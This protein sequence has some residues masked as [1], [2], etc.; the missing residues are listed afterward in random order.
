MKQSYD[1][2]IVGAGPAGVCAAI[3]CRNEGL[4][5]LL[6]DKKQYEK[7][8]DKVC[9]EAISKR[10]I[11]TVS[12]EL[13]IEKPSEKEINAHVRELVLRTSLPVDHI[14]LPAI[15]YMVN[16]HRYG[17]RLLNN[18]IEKGVVLLADTKVIKP[19]IKEGKVAG[20]IARTQKKEEKEY[21]AQVVIDCSGL[22]AVIRTNL[23][24]DFEPMLNNKLRKTDYAPCYR[25]IIELDREHDL[26]GKIVLQYEEGIPNPG[27]IWFF[28]DG[29]KRINCGTGFIKVGKD[30]DKSVKS[31]YFNAMEN[32]YPKGTYNTIDGR[33]DSVPIRPPLWNAVAPGL[34]IAGDA[35]FHA[36]P[37]TAEGHGPAM[38]AG[39]HA[40]EIASDAIKKNKTDIEGL[41][42]YNKRVIKSFGAEHARSRILTLALQ[43]LGPKRLEFLLTRKVIKQADLTSEGVLKKQ[44]IYSYLDRAMR[45]IPRF[46][47]LLL[48][49]KA[50]SASKKTA[51]LCDRYPETPNDFVS[52]RQEMEK[53]YEG[54]EK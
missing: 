6:I 15:G 50:I 44:T 20:I 52:W 40:G 41:W 36:D 21:N 46:G 39:L 1:V 35:A 54:I 19:I 45:S 48:I 7:I 37:L 25:E 3:S 31:V 47:L 16:R 10:T 23:P 30:K 34:I 43:E 26:D 4:D 12:N 18:A 8:G 24:D 27:Y 13:K 51:S 22:L 42:E 28:G 53:V 5:V 2:I 9:G 33:G 11:E 49:K 38:F 14:I 17:Q 32:Y 29:D